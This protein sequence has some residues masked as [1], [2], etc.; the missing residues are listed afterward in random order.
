LSLA[1]SKGTSKSKTFQKLIQGASQCCLQNIQIV[2]KVLP[3]III[4]QIIENLTIDTVYFHK[5]VTAE[6][7]AVEIAVKK[8]LLTLKIIV[9]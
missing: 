5:E 3:E 1:S 4:P 8:A 6:E 7:I 9:K 2:A